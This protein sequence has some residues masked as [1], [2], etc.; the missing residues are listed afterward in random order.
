MFGLMKVKIE[1]VSMIHG[2]R[3]VGFSSQYGN[4]TA[5]WDGDFPEEGKEYFVEI[6]IGE[7]F[8]V[9]DNLTICDEGKFCIEV[10]ADVISLTGCLASI[11]EDGYAVLR[12]GDSSVPL[13]VIGAIP[14]ESFV[15]I[16]SDGV[17]LFDATN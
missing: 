1:K 12:V 17:T 14:A 4:A 8:T 9:G 11:E 5:N 10:E 7:T 3:K 2:N 6:E 15:R 13:E 16:T